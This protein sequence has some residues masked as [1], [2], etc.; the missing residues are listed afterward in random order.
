[1]K[2]G[3][4]GATVTNVYGIK[5]TERHRTD[6]LKEIGIAGRRGVRVGACVRALRRAGA[7]NLWFAD[8]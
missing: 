3:I 7:I 6:F 4:V 8:F 5:R 1:M 2:N